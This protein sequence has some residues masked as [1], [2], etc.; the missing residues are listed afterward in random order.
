MFPACIA[1]NFKTSIILFFLLAG[2][3]VTHPILSQNSQA[4]MEVDPTKKI[5]SEISLVAGASVV[6][7]RGNKETE[8][9]RQLKIGY[10]LG[11]GALHK[12]NNRLAVQARF[13]YE[14][15]GNK[16]ELTTTYFDQNDQAYKKGQVTVDANYQYITLP[17]T[18]VWYLG[19]KSNFHLSGGMFVGYL[20]KQTTTDTFH[21]SFGGGTPSI[22]TIDNTENYQ[23]LDG[24]VVG[25]LGFHLPAGRRSLTIG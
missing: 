14:R 1:V 10:C 25:G 24:G 15:K 17:V 19:G 2:F 11:V 23:K 8:D 18:V 3:L 12:F 22:Q 7:L 9:S 4:V 16:Q 13:L 21:F 5:L 20:L 6:S